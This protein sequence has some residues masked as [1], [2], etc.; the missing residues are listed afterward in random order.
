MTGEQLAFEKTG[1]VETPK[2]QTVMLESMTLDAFRAWRQT[3]GVII[4]TGCGY[5]L[6]LDSRCYLPDLKNALDGLLVNLMA[7]ELRLF[8]E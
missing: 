4:L 1:K 5:E 6:K 2:G 7:Q 3:E 8:E